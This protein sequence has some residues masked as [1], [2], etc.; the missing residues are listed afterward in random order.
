[1]QSAE[2][3]VWEEF[4]SKFYSPIRGLL[5]MTAAA[6]LSVPALA[7]PAHLTAVYLGQHKAQAEARVK[8][9]ETASAVL[10]KSD[11]V[12]E[13]PDDAMDRDDRKTTPTSRKDPK[14][15]R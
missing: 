9:V 8:P 4:M 6:S 2:K 14:G 7:A 11:A 12:A 3:D 15:G 1:M 10:E 13:K 5:V